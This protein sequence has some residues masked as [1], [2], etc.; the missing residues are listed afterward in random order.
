MAM[1]ARTAQDYALSF[2]A[3][4]PPGIAWNREPDSR[5]SRL[6]LAWGDELARAD[7]R[8]F[9]LITELDPREAN[10]LLADWERIVGLPDPCVTARVDELTSRQRRDMAHA[11]LTMVGGQSAAWYKARLNAFGY[12]VEIS[13]FALHNV[14]STVAA[15]L[16]A[17]PWNC[18]WKITAARAEIRIFAVTD[19]VADPLAWWGD[20]SL[21]CLI[22]AIAP[23][24]SLP[25]FAYLNTGESHGS[26]L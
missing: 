22:R 23:A 1:S 11:R 17:P 7:A 25:V 4:L 10:E 20:A 2:A 16:Y 3:L 24:H 21:E 9:A 6:L 26:P 8:V 5:L 19:T 15:P 14:D 18:A 13:E 12:D